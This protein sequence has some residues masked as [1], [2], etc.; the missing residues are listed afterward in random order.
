MAAVPT[1]GPFPELTRP[2]DAP[3]VLQAA[4]RRDVAEILKGRWIAFGHLPLQVDNPPHWHKDYLAGIDL[5]TRQSA[6]KLHHRLE[7]KADIKLIW[8]PS[9]W[10]SLVRLAQG[11][12]VLGDQGAATQCLAWLSHWCQQNPPYYGWNWTSALET[13]LRLIQFV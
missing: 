12:F 8:E 7:G 3:A 4:L 9:R 10:Y 13:G 1:G 11:A 6:L 2:G 5:A